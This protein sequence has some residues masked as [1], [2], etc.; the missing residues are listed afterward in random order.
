M[1]RKRYAHPWTRSDIR[2]RIVD[3]VILFVVTTV[4][5]TVTVAL[6]EAQQ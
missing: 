5:I 1:A 3:A 4:W 2:A 6:M